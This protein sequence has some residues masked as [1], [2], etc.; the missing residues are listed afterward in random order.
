MKVVKSMRSVFTLVKYN[1]KLMADLKTLT[2]LEKY[3]IY[4]LSNPDVG[5]SFSDDYVQRIIRQLTKKYG[6]FIVDTATI[7]IEHASEETEDAIYLAI[8]ETLNQKGFV[9]YYNDNPFK[10]TQEEINM[11]EQEIERYKNKD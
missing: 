10:L 4:E 2:P 7:E 9:D 1:P 8:K 6:D 3:L 11:I 5:T